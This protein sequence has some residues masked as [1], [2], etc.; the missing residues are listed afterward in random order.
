MEPN[1]EIS[2]TKV[3]IEN[4]VENWQ[5]VVEWE[6]STNAETDDVRRE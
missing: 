1:I 6:N 2:Q 3:E 5:T 4:I